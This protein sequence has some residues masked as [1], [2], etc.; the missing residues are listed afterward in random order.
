MCLPLRGSQD[1]GEA[2]EKL[3]KDLQWASYRVRKAGRCSPWVQASLS[4]TSIGIA[5]CQHDDDGGAPLRDV[6]LR[7]GLVQH[8]NAPQQP[9]I[10]V[11]HCTPI[12]RQNHWGGDVLRVPEY[13]AAEVKE[14][15]GVVLVLVPRT[16]PA[17]T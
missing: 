15:G 5:I 1:A 13:K 6:A 14:S 9:I 2:Q 4:L 16:V 8:F 17:W 10:D 11:G 3:S 7:P 12:Q